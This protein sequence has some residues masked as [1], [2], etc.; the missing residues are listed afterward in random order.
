MFF[1]IKGGGWLGL[2][3]KW[4]IPLTFFWNHPLLKIHHKYFNE[5]QKFICYICGHKKTDLRRRRQIQYE[6]HNFHLTIK[7]NLSKHWK[8][9]HEQVK[10]S[11]QTL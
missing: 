11:L 4:K 2:D 7:A 10:F 1:F 3:P 6:P 9:V 5:D 8:S